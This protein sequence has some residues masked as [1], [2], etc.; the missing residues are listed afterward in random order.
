[1]IDVALRS[2]FL[3]RNGETIEASWM[4][5]GDMPQIDVVIET[6]AALG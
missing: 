2:A 5:G 4:L 3:I 6:A 1:M